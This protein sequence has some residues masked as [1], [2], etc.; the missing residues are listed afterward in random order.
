MQK[1]KSEDNLD[2]YSSVQRVWT[3][4]FVIVYHCLLLFRLS[5]WHS[6]TSGV[7]LNSGVFFFSSKNALK[8]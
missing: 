6:E 2:L 7:S 4:F 3:L 1:A 8:S 5:V